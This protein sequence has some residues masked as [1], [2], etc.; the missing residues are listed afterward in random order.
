MD[1]EV[2]PGT[3]KKGEGAAGFERV[4]VAVEGEGFVDWAPAS[5][6][7]RAAARST[8]AGVVEAGFDDRGAGEEVF[9][10]G[11]GFEGLR[12][13]SLRPLIC[14]LRSNSFSSFDFV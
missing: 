13:L 9:V 14:S 6:A 5:R 7:L 1:E 4:V 2:T 11:I 10:A 8:N 12:N 3:E